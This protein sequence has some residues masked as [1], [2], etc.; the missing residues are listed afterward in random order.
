MAETGSKNK[1]KAYYAE[2]HNLQLRI[3]HNNT[4]MYG[5][6]YG[7]GVRSVFEFGCNAGRH[8]HELQQLGMKCFGIDLNA[9]AI[10]GG[11]RLWK[12]NT[13]LKDERYLPKIKNNSYE[14][15]ITVSVLNHI[16]S[17]DPILRNL[18]RIASKYVVVC[19]CDTKTNRDGKSPWYIHDYAALGFKPVRTYKGRFDTVYTIWVLEIKQKP[20][21]AI[22]YADDQI[23]QD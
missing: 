1:D 6:L 10:R 19:E 5:L 8:L 4:F 23:R 22:S 14:A 3:R 18:K 15:C 7:L 13:K 9:K 17:I 11:K 2:Q 16:K 20:G 21:K 12:V